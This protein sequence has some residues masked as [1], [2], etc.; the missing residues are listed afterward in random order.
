MMFLSRFFV[1]STISAP[2]SIDIFLVGDRHLYATK[3]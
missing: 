1:F 2:A 3:G